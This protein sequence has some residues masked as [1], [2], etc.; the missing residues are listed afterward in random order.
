VLKH[1][2]PCQATVTVQ[3]RGDELEIRIVDDGRQPVP[4]IRTGSAGHGL[5]G[6][7]ERARIIG[8]TVTAGPRPQGGFEVRLVLPILTASG[9]PRGG[10]SE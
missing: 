2:S 7:R 5:I 8:G 4:A 3:Y 10:R 9:P 1:A 6:M